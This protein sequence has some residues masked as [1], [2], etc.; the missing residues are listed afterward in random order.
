[1]KCLAR[2]QIKPIFAR[3]KN[4]FDFVIVDTSPIMLV[5]DTLLI[6]KYVDAAVF[7]VRR[8]LSRSTRTTAACQRLTSLGIPILGS[9]VIGVDQGSSGYGSHYGYG[10]GYGTYGY[11]S[12]NGHADVT[13]AQT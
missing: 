8:D 1:L 9:V 11:G 12:R 4:E 5:V 3:F 7:A 13:E 6:G 10:Y 2:D